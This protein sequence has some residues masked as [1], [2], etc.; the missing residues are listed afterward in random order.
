MARTALVTGANKGIGLAIVRHLALQYPSSA[1]NDGPLLIYLT[2]RDEGRGQAALKS[3]HDDE[4]LRKAKALTSEG[5]LSTLKFHRLDI[6]E[7]ESI[8]DAGTFLEREHPDG[9]DIV[10][11]NAGVAMQG[12][13]KPSIPSKEQYIYLYYQIEHH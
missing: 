4:Q 11:N 9:V 10:I 1:F 13:G 6:S 8:R 7:P 5:G 2:A 12:F 3:L